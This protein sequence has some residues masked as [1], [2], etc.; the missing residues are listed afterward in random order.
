MQVLNAICYCF[1]VCL[2]IQLR[3][4]SF[5]FLGGMHFLWVKARLFRIYALLMSLV[6]ESTVC[7][8]PQHRLLKNDEAPS[9]ALGDHKELLKSE[10]ICLITSG[11]YWIC[12]EV[13][14]HSW[15]HFTGYPP[16]F[17]CAFSFGPRHRL[18]PFCKLI[19]YFPLKWMLVLAIYMCKYAE[20]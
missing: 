9:D 16:D 11:H 12:P 18:Q 5:V 17:R 14:P 4:T 19:W 13:E 8:S 2:R 15:E 6:A 1:S 7:P 10:I 20:F 3:F